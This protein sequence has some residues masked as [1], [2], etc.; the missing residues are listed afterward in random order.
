MKTRKIFKLGTLV[1]L[2]IVM[3]PLVAFTSLN[4]SYKDFIKNY[5]RPTEAKVNKQ[6]TYPLP[7]G[8]EKTGDII[9]QA[10]VED[11]FS[12]NILG[13]YVNDDD[14]NLVETYKNSENKQKYV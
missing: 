4:K 9:I 13:T 5:I 6:Y 12:T 3:V 2:L 8:F 14:I 7:D 10:E 1:I 11:S